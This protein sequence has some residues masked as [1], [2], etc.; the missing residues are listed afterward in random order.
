M[1]V[2]LAKTGSASLVMGGICWWLAKLTNIAAQQRF[3]TQL[4]QLLLIIAVSVVS[5]VIM[6]LILKSEEAKE[7]LGFIFRREMP[8]PKG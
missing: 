8:P 4:W 6:T 1:L 2:S 3:L 7:L 5:Y